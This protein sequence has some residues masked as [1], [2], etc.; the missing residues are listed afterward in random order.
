MTVRLAAN[1]RLFHAFVS[2]TNPAD[3]PSRWVLPIRPPPG[4]QKKKANERRR[5]ERLSD[6]TIAPRTTA[7]YDNAFSRFF[8]WLRTRGRNLP[9]TGTDVDA[10]LCAYFESLWTEGD[11]KGLAADAVSGFQHEFFLLR[12]QSNGAWRLLGA[13]HRN[14]LQYYPDDRI[15]RNSVVCLSKGENEK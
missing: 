11:H 13:W 1:L 10:S 9:C 2:S 5:L 12:H 7:C 14:E 4:R 3:K 15:C 6:L 8:I